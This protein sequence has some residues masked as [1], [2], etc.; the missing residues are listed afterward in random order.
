MI[1]PP[2][3]A[4][5]KLP[6]LLVDRDSLPEYVL[7][8]GDPARAA[9]IAS[10][11]EGAEELA[12]NREYRTFVGEHDGIRIAVVSTGVGASGAAA[13]FEEAIM[14]G[15]GT[16]IRVGTTG[17]LQDA[18]KTG[19]IIVATAAVRNDGVA[20]Q[21]LPVEFPAAA[22]LNVS[23]SLIEAARSHE[24]RFHCGVVGTV[25]AFYKGQLDLGLDWM[26]QAGVLSVEMECAT[27]FVVAALRGVRAGAILAVDGDAREAS[28]G[29]YDPH[30]EVV[31][32]AVSQE[33][34]IVLEAVRRLAKPDDS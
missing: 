13:A 18:V 4:A 6:L 21:L 34:D 15:A 3:S 24:G 23:D 7:L 27:L 2:M 5:K 9:A 26:S 33:I 14:A 28:G 19:D 25:G 31:C 16:L 11:L 10:R 1:Q 17:S 12:Y 30:R 22:D 29:D 20:N 32:R 8:P